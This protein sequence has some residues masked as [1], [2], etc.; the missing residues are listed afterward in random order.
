MVAH[1]RGCPVGRAWAAVM[2][3]CALTASWLVTSGEC[4][5]FGWEPTG[6]PYGG[7]VG[8]L[9][10]SPDGSLYVRPTGGGVYRLPPGTSTWYRLQDTPREPGLWPSLGDGGDSVVVDIWG[11]WFAAHSDAIYR[12]TDQGESWERWWTV[13]SNSTHITSFDV[14]GNTAVAAVG[15]GAIWRTIDAG[16]TWTRFPLNIGRVLTV[17]VSGEV[18]LAHGT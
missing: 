18:M 12:S 15:G 8:R 16:R 11:A 9:C 7:Y 6:G 3:L 2:C 14:D 17:A 1:I 10:A 5:D 4:Q 13:P